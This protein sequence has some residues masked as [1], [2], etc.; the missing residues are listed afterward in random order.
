MC[1]LAVTCLACQTALGKVVLII[2]QK[3][4][5]IAFKGL[6]VSI[7]NYD[8]KNDLRLLV[9]L[10]IQESLSKVDNCVKEKVLA[11]LL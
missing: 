1:L 4:K 3:N 11:L 6:Y 5:G 10:E 8:K 7:L 2:I 9:T